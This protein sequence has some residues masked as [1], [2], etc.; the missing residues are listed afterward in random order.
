MKLRV[1]HLTRYEYDREVSFGPHLLYLRPRESADQRLLLHRLSVQPDARINPL[2]D[3]QDNDAAIA[4][5]WE[6]ANALNIRSEFEIER[7]LAN[8]FDFILESRAIA[9]PF[10]YDS[11]T[12]VALAPCLAPPPPETAERLRAWLDERFPDR[13]AETV[14]FLTA[15]NSLLY[16]SLRYTRRHDPGIRTPVETLTLGAGACRDYAVLFVGLARVLGL[17]AR[18]VSGYLHAPA[19]DPRH[20]HGAMHAWV[21]VYLPGAGWR[22]LDPT[23][24]I[25]CDEN[26]IPVAH[27]ALAETVNPVQ[28]AVFAPGPV[29]SQLHVDIRVE[30]VDVAPPATDENARA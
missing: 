25:W 23:H 12:A 24:G 18:F 11:A 2:R 7:H 26:F 1:S 4:Y 5:F 13:P 9:F 30:R 27:G 17:A 6:R 10:A 8:P 19:D 16:Q 14:P 20:G 3:P 28:G 22:G 15:L 21:E 29:R